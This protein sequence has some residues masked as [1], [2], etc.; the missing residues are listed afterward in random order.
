M[1]QF[2]FLF[3]LFSHA[4]NLKKLSQNLYWH[5]LLHMKENVSHVDGEH[6]FL[7]KEK[8]AYSELIETL[9]YIKSEKYHPKYKDHIQCLFP[10]RT[11]WLEETLKLTLPKVT[12]EELQWWKNQFNAKGLSLVFSSYYPNNPSSFFGHTFLLVHRDKNPLFDMSIDY[13]AMGVENVNALFAIKGLIGLLPG[14]FSI[15]PYYMKVNEYTRG[16][17][18]DLWEYKLKITKNQIEQMLNHLW[19]LTKTTYFDYYFFD[20]NCSYFMLELLEIANSDWSF[21]HKLPFFVIPIDTIKAIVS[22]PGVVDKISF[23]PSFSK[24][25]K[26]KL[27]LLSSEEKNTFEKILSDKKIKTNNPKVLEALIDQYRLKFFNN[28]KLDKNDEKFLA[29]LKDVRGTLPPIK[30]EIKLEG[31][32]PDKSHA[33]SHIEL[34]LGKKFADLTLNP[35]LHKITHSN[36]GLPPFSHVEILTTTLRYKND[37]IRFK[38]SI[39]ASVLSLHSYSSFDFDPSWLSQAVINNEKRLQASFDVG[40]GTS[41]KKDNYSLYFIP[42]TRLNISRYYKNTFSLDLALNFG[43]ILSLGS[44]GKLSLLGSYFLRRK[45]SINKAVFSYYLSRK[46]TLLAQSVF[47]FNTFPL[48]KSKES[49]LSFVYFF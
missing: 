5:R 23:R 35:A 8:S 25:A 15:K 6:F 3:C 49:S 30:E 40:I 27:A 4:E 13:A 10:A 24:K 16:E 9:K 17:G 46:I 32:R 28:H 39:L 20:E 21:T 43:G 48:N 38:E 18:R 7:S 37:Q 36:E 34:S 2:L 11:K 31:K 22:E 19:E 12:C 26:A 1:R 44:W 14:I 33:T 42:G 47:S 29:S 41:V 45:E